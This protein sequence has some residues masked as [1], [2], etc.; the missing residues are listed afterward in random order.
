MGLACGWRL[1][2]LGARV[3]LFDARE[4]GQGATLASLGALWPSSALRHKPLP[5]LHRRS[6]WAF[7]EFVHE[8][9]AFSEIPVGFRRLGHLELLPPERPMERVREEAAAACAQWPAFSP[10]MPQ[11]QVLS[12]AEARQLQPGLSALAMPARLCRNTAQVRVP[13]L[14]AALHAAC[15]RAGAELHEHTAITGIDVRDG[16]AAGVKIAGGTVAAD[17]VLITAGAWSPLLDP[18]IEQA[19]PIRPAK[20]QALALAPPPEVNLR[21]ILKSG[22]IYLVPWQGDGGSRQNAGQGAAHNEILVGSTTEP[23]A[24]FD[25]SPTQKAREMLFA[26]AATLL[27]AL[28]NARILRHWSG[29]R[30][31]TTARPHLPVMGPHPAIKGLHI[32]AGHFKTGIGLAPLVSR[33]IAESMI[34]GAEAPEFAPFRP[35]LGAVEP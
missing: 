19:A 9:A 2:R 6:L 10:G 26:G 31:Q 3:V 17:A 15:L 35:S 4:A 25:E 21:M 1:A 13:D 28:Q 14:V 34:S 8:L 12:S 27:P 32:C 7:E 16:K 33:S 20:G 11:M 29:L 22:S 18:L 24:G 30:P 23:E 5:E